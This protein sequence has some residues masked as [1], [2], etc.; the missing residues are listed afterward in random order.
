M[1]R[2]L[3]YILVGILVYLI[4]FYMENYQPELLTDILIQVDVMGITPVAQHEQHRLSQIQDLTIPYEEKQVLIKRTVFIGAEPD[5]VKLALGEPKKI[6]EKRA[7]G[8]EPT[9]LYYVYYLPNDK[10]PTIFVFQNNVLKDA[11]KDS[12][13]NI[14][15]Y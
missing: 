8:K 10:R 4:L 5:M 6:F 15:N 13:I 3:P 1:L 9:F 12:T 7:T 11:Y 14:G 2:A